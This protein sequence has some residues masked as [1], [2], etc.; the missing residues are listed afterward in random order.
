MSTAV[1]TERIKESS[2]RSLARTT[3]VLY[4]LTIL[5]G[6]FSAGYVTGKLVVSGDAA[7]TAANILAHL[8][9]CSWVSQS[10]SLK[11]RARSPSQLS[12]ITC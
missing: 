6:I 1:M 3:G 9:C 10:T 11:W 12:F 8:A 7:A 2:L 5:T 4:L